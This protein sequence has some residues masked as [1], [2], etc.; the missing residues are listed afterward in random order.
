M[1]TRKSLADT[2]DAYDDQIAEL[3]KSKRETYDAYRDQMVDA[4]LTKPEI[5]AEIEAVKVA[6]KRRRE[7]LK[8]SNALIEKDALVDEVFAEITR[9]PRATREIIEKIASDGTKYDATSGEILDGD[10][11]AKLIATV[12]TAMQT[13]IGRKALGAAVDIMIAREEAEEEFHTNP[14]EEAEAK[15]AATVE[16][17]DRAEGDTDRQRSPEAGTT[18]G[19]RQGVR[20]QVASSPVPA[21]DA[22]E[23]NTEMPLS[24]DDGAPGR[25]DANTGGEHVAAHSSAATEPARAIVSRAPAKPLRPHCRNPGEHCGGYGSNHCHSCMRAAREAEVAA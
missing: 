12:A 11:S 18:D 6:I 20:E 21:F 5:K 3:N 14:E 25:P 9:A 23:G 4:R 22:P 2:I 10:V 7:S 24:V 8:D 13:D 16:A 15:G 1:I 17:E 19:G